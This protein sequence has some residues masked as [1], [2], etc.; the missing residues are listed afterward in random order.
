[1]FFT[2]PELF[3]AITFAVKV[4]FFLFSFLNALAFSQC[5]AIQSFT[6]SGFCFVSS[7]KGTITHPKSVCLP[8]SANLIKAPVASFLV[9][10]TF[11]EGTDVALSH[12]ALISA[13]FNF[14][15]ILLSYN[16]LSISTYIII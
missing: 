6:V 9:I 15:V 2:I 14:I 8:N 4:L 5:K 11:L 1:M 7:I 10:E 12:I 3:S 13:S 16:L